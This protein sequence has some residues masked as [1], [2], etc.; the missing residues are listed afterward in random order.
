MQKRAVHIFISVLF[1]AVVA[2]FSPFSAFADDQTTIICLDKE[3]STYDIGETLTFTI[4]VSSPDGGYITSAYCGFGYN[5]ST[6]ELISE[7][8][9]PDHIW[10]RNGSASRWLYSKEITFRV[11]SDGKIYF[12]AGA[13]SGNGVIQAYK[14]DGSRVACPRASVV[15]KA[16]TGIYTPTSDCNAKSIR[17]FSAKT[18]EQIELNRRFDKY[19]TEY[20]A[21]VPADLEGVTIEAEAEADTDEVVL[22]DGGKVTLH[23]GD[24]E[25]VV[26]IKSPDGTK[27]YTFV[28]H[29]PEEEISVKTIHVTDENGKE[30]DYRFSIGEYEYD[31]TVD[32]AVK[33]VYFEVEVN[34]KTRATYPE[35]EELTPGYSFR[36]VTVE[37]GSDSREYTYYIYRKLSQLSLSSLI[38]EGS[39]ELVYDLD[40]EFSPDVTEYSISV[41]SDVQKLTITCTVGNEEDHI[42]EDLSAPF[43]LTAGTNIIPITVTD[44][45]NENVYTLTVE[46]DAAP[47]AEWIKTDDG[48]DEDTPVNSI[49]LSYE[50][51][52]LN[53]LIPTAAVILIGIVAAIVI[54]AG[55]AKKDYDKSSEAAG[56]RLDREREKRLKQMDKELKQKIDQ[57]V[58]EIKK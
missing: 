52:N 41:P 49:Q 45:T 22:P 14:A 27:D 54:A 18:G 38:V 51:K 7:T 10:I 34:G 8:D 53:F 6:M 21:E 36:S 19:S 37:N 11:K 58:K 2:A 13:Y 20:S 26:G 32:N 43:E 1:A 3:K 57:K 15:Y 24:N 5:Q 29:K 48:L 17:L 23:S 56:A 39:D 30:I 40:K 55:K 33:H 12:I 28:L 44:G 50:K 31:I 9:T 25:I 4:G 47:E 42:K 35:D 16:G 46:K